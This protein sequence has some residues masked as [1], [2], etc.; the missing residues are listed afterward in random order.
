MKLTTYE[1]PKSSFLSVDKDL[2]IICDKIVKNKRL[3]KYLYY[4]VE[5][6]LQMEDLTLEETGELFGKYIRI[7]PKLQID[8]EVLNYI[9]VSC[10]NFTPNATNP[11]FRDNII[12][13]D[14][15]CHY[16][17]WQMKDFE[18]RPYK[19]AGEIDSMLNGKKLTGI[20]QLEFLGA[21]QL[22]LTEE[23]AGICLMYSAI[24]G[25]EDKQGMPNPIDEEQFLADFEKMLNT[26]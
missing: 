22:I 3:Q 18:L 23:Y 15:I 1:I 24:H 19:I 17:Q 16:D 14:I 11:E 6:P 25:I 7:V 4:N 9:I 21:S 26:K 8:G 12:E 5:N 10:D 13:F 20:G 2:S